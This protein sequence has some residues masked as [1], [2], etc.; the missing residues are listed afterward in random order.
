MF[1]LS[2]MSSTELRTLKDKLHTDEQKLEFL[3]AVDRFLKAHPLDG[4]ADSDTVYVVGRL[5]TSEGIWDVIPADMFR[6][7]LH[8]IDPASLSVF[9]ETAP[10]YLS[11]LER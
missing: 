8:D 3:K 6:W 4:G 10:E 11:Q 9:L 1:S 5:L 7:H 2:A